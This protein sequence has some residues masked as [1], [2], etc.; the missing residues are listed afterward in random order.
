MLKTCANQSCGKEFT[1]N[2]H[3]Q[4]YCNPDCCRTA[5]NAKLMVQYYAKKE[6]RSGVKRVCVRCRT[7]LSRYNNTS[8]CGPCGETLE[9]SR[10]MEVLS[11][12]R[13]TVIRNL[14]VN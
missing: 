2:T 10:N 3:N 1:P 5:T 12:F 13:N 14:D 11:M 4:K 8:T 9:A 7:G 6:I